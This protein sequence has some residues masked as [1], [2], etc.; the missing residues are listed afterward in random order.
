MI[1]EVDASNPFWS[2]LRTAE[3]IML[4]FC[5]AYVASIAELLQKKVIESGQVRS[6]SYDD[7]SGTTFDRF[8]DRNHDL[9]NLL[10]LTEMEALRD[11]FQKMTTS[12]LV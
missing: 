8:S 5:V 6:R 4:K 2:G 11:L 12:D 9:R 10:P 3:Q 7:I 1:E